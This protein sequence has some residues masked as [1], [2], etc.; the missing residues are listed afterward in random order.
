MA[1]ITQTK[2]YVNAFTEYETD[3]GSESTAA[4]HMQI[5]ATEE[6]ALSL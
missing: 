1:M 4:C 5:A 3:C 6:T 2:I